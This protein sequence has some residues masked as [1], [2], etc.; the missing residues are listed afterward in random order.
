MSNVYVGYSP[1]DFFYAD[2]PNNDYFPTPEECGNLLASSWEHSHCT[3]WFSDNSLNCIK[4]E[5]CKNQQNVNSINTVD[6]SHNSIYAKNTD[7]SSEFQDTF[8]NTINLGI[9]VLFVILMIFKIQ[10][11]GKNKN[12][13]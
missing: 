8:L 11:T 7:N 6:A 4:R 3:A 13:I 9:G 10:S 5:I 2:N 12:I 1:N